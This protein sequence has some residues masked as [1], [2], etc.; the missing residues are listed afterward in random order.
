METTNK[1]YLEISKKVYKPLSAFVLKLAKSLILEEPGN[2]ALFSKTEVHTKLDMKIENAL[3]NFIESKWKGLFGIVAEENKINIKNGK[4]CFFI[5]PLDGTRN[6]LARNPL[7]CISIGLWDVIDQKPILGIVYSPL[8]QELFG[9]SYG[10]IATLNGKP[11]K[12]SKIKNLKQSIV[13]TAFLRQ[14]DKFKSNWDRMSHCYKS[15]SSKVYGFRTIQADALSVSW[16]ACGRLDAALL[17]STRNFDIA[18]GLAILQ[19]V[20]GIHIDLLH[21]DK[22]INLVNDKFDLLVSNPYIFGKIISVLK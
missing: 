14:K 5:D 13:G 8:N 15:L 9:W 6:S 21:P 10:K 12:L 20:G 22:N 7:F 2:S 11:I 18:G 19:G 4:Y 3:I 17:V 16:V 1:D